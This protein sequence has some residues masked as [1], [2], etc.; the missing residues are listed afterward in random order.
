MEL[1]FSFLS[2]VFF[3]AAISAF[4]SPAAIGGTG[5]QLFPATDVSK[6]RVSQAKTQGTTQLWMHLQEARGKATLGQSCQ[7][8]SETE[9]RVSVRHPVY[10]S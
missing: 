7:N 9:Q 2:H 1:I 3:W 5:W 6:Y 10:L 8:L 4:I